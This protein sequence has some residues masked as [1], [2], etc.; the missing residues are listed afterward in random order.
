MNLRKKQG[1]LNFKPASWQATRLYLGEGYKKQ[2]WSCNLQ[3][4][5][6]IP[7]LV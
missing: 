6:I 2:K 3:L 1:A 5:F 7:L 4:R